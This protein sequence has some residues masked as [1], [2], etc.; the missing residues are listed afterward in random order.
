MDNTIIALILLIGVF[1]F[2]AIILGAMGLNFGSYLQG[3]MQA[4]QNF[5]AP[6]KTGATTATTTPTN[7]GSST[8]TI[9]GGNASGNS[10]GGAG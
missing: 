4:G 5:F 3:S 7:S 10:G 1:V 9:G 8:F 6:Y 2:F